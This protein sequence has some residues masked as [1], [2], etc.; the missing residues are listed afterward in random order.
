MA[1]KAVKKYYIEIPKQCKITE[2]TS[3]F[4][5]FIPLND[6]LWMLKYEVTNDWYRPFYEQN[7]TNTE[8]DSIFPINVSINYLLNKGKGD[9]LYFNL[10]KFF[11]QLPLIV[12]SL[13]TNSIN[14]FLEWLTQELK[15]NESFKKE[16]NCDYLIRLPTKEEWE[17]AASSG[18][19]YTFGWTGIPK[20]IYYKE[21]YIFDKYSYPRANFKN[22]FKL[23]TDLKYSGAITIDKVGKNSFTFHGFAAIHELMCVCSYEPNELGFYNMTGNVAELLNNRNTAKGGSYV[24]ELMSINYD[25]NLSYPITHKMEYALGIRPVI[26]VK[27]N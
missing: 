1:R 22:S 6:T 12:T 21:G 3:I 16:A 15:A 25:I 2:N 27:C 5:N 4:S 11:G 19:K 20:S 13:G 9:S 7:F 24:S 26:V 10:S 18:G 14:G 23:L 17:Y 8:Y